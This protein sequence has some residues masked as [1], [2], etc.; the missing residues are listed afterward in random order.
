MGSRDQISRRRLHRQGFSERR[1]HAVLA[2]TPVDQD[3]DQVVTDQAK[4]T[5]QHLPR[6]EKGC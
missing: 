5:S 3:R 2:W 4:L 6:N 1:N